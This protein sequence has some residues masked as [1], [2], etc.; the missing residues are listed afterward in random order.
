M[1]PVLFRREIL[2]FG[3]PYI[4]KTNRQKIL[5]FDTYPL[6]T[7]V[8]LHLTC[9]GKYIWK[10]IKYFL[11]LVLDSLIPHF[12]YKKYVY[13]NG[14]L[15]VTPAYFNVT[16]SKCVQ[17]QIMSSFF[18]SFWGNVF[19][20]ELRKKKKTVYK[21]KKKSSYSQF[22]RFDFRISS[23]NNFAKNTTSKTEQA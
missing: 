13:I 21:I 5:I 20:I 10:L 7:S 23:H 1:Y 2:F 6:S 4:L 18:Y 14:S 15:W 8:P 9:A 3:F 12:L 22:S 16:L 17:L 11:A 19:L